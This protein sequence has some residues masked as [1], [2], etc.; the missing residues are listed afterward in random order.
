LRRPLQ[1]LPIPSRCTVIEY[2]AQIKNLNASI[3]YAQAHAQSRILQV[4]KK[5]NEQEKARV[6]A[7]LESARR[8]KLEMEGGLGQR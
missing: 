8:Y 2:E 6:E 5:R 3:A 4:E 7:L 1:L